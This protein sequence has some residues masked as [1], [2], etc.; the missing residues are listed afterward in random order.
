MMII[1]RR[2][3]LLMALMFWQGGFTR[4]NGTPKSL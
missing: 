3:L 1:L 4:C 2:F